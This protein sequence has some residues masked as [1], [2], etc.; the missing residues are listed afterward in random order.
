MFQVMQTRVH[1]HAMKWKVMTKVCK[2]MKKAKVT[3]KLIKQVNQY[4][5][6][7]QSPKWMWPLHFYDG[8][9]DILECLEQLWAIYCLC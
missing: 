4:V 3:L 2:T 9:P 6:T 7:H 1:L 5:K 8:S